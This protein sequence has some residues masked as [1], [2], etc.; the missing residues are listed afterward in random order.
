MDATPKS[1]KLPRILKGVFA[2]NYS[3][4]WNYCTVLNRMMATAS[5]TIPSPKTNENNFGCSSYLMIDIA[6]ITSE[7]HNN[8]HTKRQSII[9]KLNP[10]MLLLK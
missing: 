7:E 8:E 10:T 6:A 5:L 2:V 4:S 1:K 9:S 3:P